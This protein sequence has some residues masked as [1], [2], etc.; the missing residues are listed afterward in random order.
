VALVVTAAD[1]ARVL[2]AQPG[3]HEYVVRL[4]LGSFGNTLSQPPKL[5][6]V[7]EERR[8]R[9]A[10]PS[11]C[12]R[13]PPPGPGGKPQSAAVAPRRRQPLAGVEH[14]DGRSG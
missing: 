4:R 8:R 3:G 10:H 2:Q 6:P 1:G 12:V 7:G 14:E 13:L 11:E 9:C 5:G